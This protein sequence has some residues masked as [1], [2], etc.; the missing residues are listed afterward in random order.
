MLLRVQFASKV[1]ETELGKETFRY[2][3]ERKHICSELMCCVFSLAYT[4]SYSL[5]S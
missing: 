5:I 3:R 2:E 4:E 1:H